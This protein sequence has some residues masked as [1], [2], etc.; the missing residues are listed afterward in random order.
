LLLLLLLLLLTTTTTTMT[1]VLLLKAEVDAAA[2]FQI[3]H[4]MLREFSRS[5]RPVS[6]WTMDQR[7]SRLRDGM[8]MLQRMMTGREV[9]PNFFLP[10]TIPDIMAD[11][12]QAERDFLFIIFRIGERLF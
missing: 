10:I 11:V 4:L 2:L 3:K 6:V 12:P 7:V 9:V 5:D 1:M 8:V